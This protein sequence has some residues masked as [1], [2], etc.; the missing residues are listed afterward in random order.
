MSSLKIN[1]IIADGTLALNGTF[2]FNPSPTYTGLIPTEKSNNTKGASTAYSDRAT[3]NL[4]LNS[5]NTAGDIWALIQSFNAITFNG[6]TITGANNITCG[7]SGST[8]VNQV[9]NFSISPSQSGSTN[10]LTSITPLRGLPNTGNT[11]SSY[12]VIGTI[13]AGSYI[14]QFTQNFNPFAGT[15]SVLTFNIGTSA[16]GSQVH[17]QIR[18]QPPGGTVYK[19][20]TLNATAIWKST[21]AFNLYASAQMSGGASSMRAVSGGYF[22]YM[23]I[24]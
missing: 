9:G 4:L 1:T 19:V 2:G 14:I 8:T 20:L 15:N 3:T 13:P 7:T 22:T 17:R 5:H 10:I 12:T 16:G 11:V 23:R 21:S 18:P 24:A 6:L